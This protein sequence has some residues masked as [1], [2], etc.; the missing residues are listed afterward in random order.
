MDEN[1]LLFQS[2][3]IGAIHANKTPNPVSTGSAPV[4]VKV[5]ST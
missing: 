4:T 1:A 3:L 5:L 2:L